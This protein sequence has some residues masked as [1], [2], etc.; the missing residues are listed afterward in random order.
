VPDVD[1]GGGGGG[2]T[3]RGAC[4]TRSRLLPVPRRR[5]CARAAAAAAKA[6]LELYKKIS[7]EER[8]A[9]RANVTRLMGMTPA[10]IEASYARTGCLRP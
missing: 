2:Q 1:D 3:E 9:A 4:R 7:E 6:R 10:E 5:R 8:A